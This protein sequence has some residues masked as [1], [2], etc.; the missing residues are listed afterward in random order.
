ME[1][2][3]LRRYFNNIDKRLDTFERSISEQIDDLAS[4]TN[5]NFV[6][7]EERFDAVD[8]RFDGLEER[9]ITIE[10][11]MVTKDDLPFLKIK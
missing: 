1:D 5:K 9:I 10:D 7:M 2:I 4:I 11:H 3:E 8:K 6:V